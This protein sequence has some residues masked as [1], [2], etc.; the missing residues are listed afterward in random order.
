MSIIGGIRAYTDP[1][2][3]EKN[4]VLGFRMVY[5]PGMTYFEY[6]EKIS[7]FNWPVQYHVKEIDYAKITKSPESAK[8]FANKF[9]GIGGMDYKIIVIVALAIFVVV[10]LKK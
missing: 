7:H 5:K 8:K 6:E 3:I 9:S 4:Q 10:F 1:G 2:I